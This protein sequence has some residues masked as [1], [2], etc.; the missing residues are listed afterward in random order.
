MPGALF[1]LRSWLDNRTGI[2]FVSDGAG[3]VLDNVGSYIAEHVADQL[4]FQVLTSYKGLRDSIVHFAAP[5][6]YLKNGICH[7]VHPSNTQLLTWTHGLPDNPDPGIQNQLS[8]F[9][10]SEP[11]LARIHIQTTTA[12]D[13]LISQG[14]SPE[15][16]VLISLGIDT[17]VFHPPTDAQRHAARQRLGV[18]DDA[19]CIGSFQKD[20]PGWD[21]SRTSMKWVK[22][23]DVLVDVLE[24]LAQSHPIFV[25]LT[26]PARGYVISRL[27]QVGI[28]YYHEDV[29]YVGALPPY[30]HALDAYLIPARDEGGPQ[31]LLEAMASGIPVVSTR[32]GIPKDVIVHGENG[33]LADIEDVAGLVE[34][35]EGLMSDSGRASRIAH[36]AR[37]MIEEYDW[38]IIADAYTRLFYQVG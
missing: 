20:S 10:E 17:R 14:V 36:K 38:S 3:W 35:V 1:S 30:Y 24:R 11:Y 19:F 29:P 8:Y 4:R 16:L 32:M 37:Q 31:A 27:E 26:T 28:P 7:D 13:F 33:W 23:P 9:A 22:G 25:L 21:N 2:A 34:G 15:K 5:P 18:P 12:R 6:I